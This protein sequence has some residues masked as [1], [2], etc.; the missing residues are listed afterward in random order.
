MSEREA[1]L[2]E[3]KLALCDNGDT[4]THYDCTGVRNMAD[5]IV[6]LRQRVREVERER[7]EA[8]R[9]RDEDR[10][11]VVL[12]QRQRDVYA[13]RITELEDRVKRAWRV[14]ASAEDFISY[15]GTAQEPRYYD[16]LVAEVTMERLALSVEGTGR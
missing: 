1:V 5:E 15:Q 16:A 2:K 9:E 12:L 13:Q 10:R 11:G 7:D 4:C 14:F 3:F 6:R 8:Q